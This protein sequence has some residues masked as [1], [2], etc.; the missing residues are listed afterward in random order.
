MI[1]D[2]KEEHPHQKLSEM[3]LAPC[4]ESS[5]TSCS[6]MRQSST[7]DTRLG[8][9]SSTRFPD[10]SLSP[11]LCWEAL[12]LPRRLWAQQGQAFLTSGWVSSIHCYQAENTKNK[13]SLELRLQD[14]VLQIAPG[15]LNG[16]EALAL[17]VKEL[18]DQP[19][20]HHRLGEDPQATAAQVTSPRTK[21]SRADEVGLF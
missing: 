10:Y 9:P 8:C 16:C 3:F 2:R 12:N 19:Q 20:E 7:A 14:E 15:Q 6:K 11:S 13:F 17:L 1:L 4:T 5:Q 21:H 18:R